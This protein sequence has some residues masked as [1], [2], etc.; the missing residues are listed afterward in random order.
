MRFV[1]NV[2]ILFVK[3]FWKSLMELLEYNSSFYL[4]YGR[5]SVYMLLKLHSDQYMG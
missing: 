5:L 1:S 2:Y 4:L 3:K